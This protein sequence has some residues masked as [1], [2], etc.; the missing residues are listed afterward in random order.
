[1]CAMLESILRASGKSTGLY[2]SPHLCRFA[3]RIRVN[4]VPIDDALLEAVVGRALEATPELTFFEATTLAAFLAFRERKVDTWVLEVGLGGRL[5]ATNIVEHP[6][7]TVITRI[8]FD[9]TDKLG[10]TLASIAR[11]KAG[12]L[13]P[14]APV[15]LGDIFG[16][17]KDAILARAREVS[18]P[19]TFALADPRAR[20]LAD[21]AALSMAGA[22]QR[23]NA[24]VAAAAALLLGVS[25]EDIVRGLSRAE[26]PGRLETIRARGTT[27]LLD[28]AHNPDGARALAR[29]L[30]TY[31]VVAVLVFGAL[32]DKAWREMLPVL[33][34]R[35]RDRVYVSPNG[36]APASPEEMRL[37]AEG[38]VASS[39][40]EALETAIGLAHGRALPKGAPNE[41]GRDPLVVVTGSIYLV[42]EVRAELLGLPRDPAVAL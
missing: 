5:D 23:E 40:P 17:A 35:A 33:A 12:I 39:V 27:F 32:A 1:V 8:D 42:G 3:E 22:H 37:V 21:E 26:W 28:C 6:A 7:V 29:H 14:G 4:G 30:S 41:A 9:H 36:R 20:A 15:V 24:T 18:A 13:K 10:T 34:A 16:E 31:P 2:T 19:V 11:E 25:G 38:V